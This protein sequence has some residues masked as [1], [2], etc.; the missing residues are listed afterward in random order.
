MATCIELRQI[1]ELICAPAISKGQVAYLNVLVEEYIFSR[2]DTFPNQPLKP[3][4]HYVLHYPDL[5]IC[6]G[7]LIRLWTLR[8]ESKHTYFKQCAQKLHNF[9]NLCS[10]LR[11][12]HQ[13]LQAY[14]SSG[15]VFPQS[16]VVERSTNFYID[17]YNE[18]IHT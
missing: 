6:F 18:K 14:L 3:K 1:V 12:R 10:T 16:L 8:F 7:P 4:H 17:D 15:A 9:K 13:L 2:R 11:E 5:I